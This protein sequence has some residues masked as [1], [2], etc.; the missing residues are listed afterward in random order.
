[1]ALLQSVSVIGFAE[2]LSIII[3]VVTARLVYFA[4]LHPLS[5]YPGPRLA[6]QTYLWQVAVLL[7]QACRSVASAF[8]TGYLRIT[9]IFS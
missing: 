5:I 2:T 6:A 7:S 8:R 3:I 9:P 1:M 4:F